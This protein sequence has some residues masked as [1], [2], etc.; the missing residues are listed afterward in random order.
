VGL[1]RKEKEKRKRKKKGKE[2]QRNAKKVT[3]SETTYLRTCS[4]LSR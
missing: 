1:K 2:M 3:H 4:N